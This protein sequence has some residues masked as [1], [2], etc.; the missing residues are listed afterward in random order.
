V[1]FRAGPNRSVETF[2]NDLHFAVSAV[3]A[4]EQSKAA[5]VRLEAQP[6]DLGYGAQF[7]VDLQSVQPIRADLAEV[8]FA[9]GLHQAARIH[10]QSGIE[11]SQSSSPAY[12]SGDYVSS[13]NKIPLGGQYCIRAYR[14][15]RYSDARA[16]AYSRNLLNTFSCYWVSVSLW[17]GYTIGGAGCNSL[18]WLGSGSAK[19]STS[20]VTGW[21]NNPPPWK[22][23]ICSAHAGWSQNWILYI[24]WEGFTLWV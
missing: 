15:Y 19:T 22:D 17:E 13:S 16:Y 10:T 2:E 14:Q 5:Q 1:V 6:I 11:V 3:R 18:Y 23:A 24:A 20:S 12:R 7:A 4:A 9:L 21:V 8:D